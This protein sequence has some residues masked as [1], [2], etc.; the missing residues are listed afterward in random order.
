MPRPRVQPQNRLRSAKA[1]D[2]CKASKRRCDSKQPCRTC[3]DKSQANSCTYS[4]PSKRKASRQAAAGRAPLTPSVPS[5][6]AGSHSSDLPPRSPRLTETVDVPGT[7]IQQPV[8]LSSSSV[9]VGTT[10]AISFLQFLQKTLEHYVGPS[11]FTDGQH[12]RKLF[13]AR[14][15]DVDVDNFQDSLEDEEKRALI[16]CF[17]EVSSGLLDLFTSEEIAQLLERDRADRASEYGS[18]KQMSKADHASLHLMVAIG[19]QCRGDNAAT[20]LPRAA[21]HF[22]VARKMALEEMLEDPTVH[23]V[24]IFLLM[25]FYM[26]GACRRNAA[27]MYMGMAS[28]AADIVGLHVSAHI[29]H[30]SSTERNIRLRTANSLRVFDIICSSILGRHASSTPLQSFDICPSDLGQEPRHHRCLALSATYELSVVL[31]EAVRKFAEEGKLKASAADNFLQRLRNWSHSLPTQLRQQLRNHPGS[32][33]NANFRELT[34]GNIHV[35]GAYYFGVILVTRPFLVQQIMPQLRGRPAPPIEP[36]E[37]DRAAYSG[38]AAE[39]SQAC[40]EA[41]TYMVEMC[42][43]AIDTSAIWGNMC[44]LKAWVFAAGLVLGFSLLVDTAANSDTNEAFLS[45]RQVLQ[46]LGRLSPQAAQYHHILTAFSDAINVYK[47]QLSREKRKSRPLLVERILPLNRT[48]CNGGIQEPLQLPP[49]SSTVGGESADLEDEVT[50]FL[51]DALTPQAVLG[52]WPQTADEELMLQLIWD[53]CTMNFVDP[54]LQ[55][56]YN[57]PS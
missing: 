51:P 36:L 20:D 54:G 15:Y 7:H 56:Q 1:C 12:S 32:D 14:T 37:E 39:F 18:A 55:N 16:Q 53:G 6:R 19:A 35:A 21:K 9:F 52:Q 22:S 2:A 49:P 41:A 34:I 46:H 57:G 24:R 42:S 40:V 45:S 25:A 3:T 50:T 27:F 23:V 10:A 8:M 47:E 44:I 48:D 38:K 28:K 13:E 33:V 31:D 4:R 17:L 30:Q 43:E 11:G 5:P 26:L 29:R